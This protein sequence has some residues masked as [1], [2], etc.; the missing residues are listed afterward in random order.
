MLPLGDSARVMGQQDDNQWSAPTNLSVSGSVGAPQIVSHSD[1]TLIVLWPDSFEERFVFSSLESDVWSEPR[2]VE[3]PFGTNAFDP[4]LSED[5][6]TPLFNAELFVDLNGRLHATWIDGDGTLFYS[7]V[8]LAEFDSLTAWTVPVE[9]AAETRLA[10]LVVEGEQELHIAYLQVGDFESQSGVYY[11]RSEDGGEN[12]TDPV[13]LYLSQYFRLLTAET[14]NIQFVRNNGNDL[15]VAWD[16][17]PNGRVMMAQSF[18][19]GNVWQELTVIDEPDESDGLVAVTPSSV[20]LTVDNDDALHIIWQVEGGE[21]DCSLYHLWLSDGSVAMQ[22]AIEELEIVDG[23]SDDIRFLNGD[24]LMLY[25]LISDERYLSVWNETEWTT[26]VVQ[27]G[28]SSFVTDSTFRE[29]SFSCGQDIIL[30]DDGLLAASCGQELAQDIWVQERALAELVEAPQI[31]QIWQT[32]DLVAETETGIVSPILIA[33]EVE[34]LHAFWSIIPSG[35]DLMQDSLPTN[36]LHSSWDMASWSRAT[37]VLQSPTGAA[38]QHAATSDGN[39]RVLVVWAGGNRGAIFFSWAGS[40]NASL[41]SEWTPPLQLSADETIASDPVIAV[42]SSGTIYVIFAVSINEGRGLYLVK[43]QDRGNT[44]SNPTMIFDGAAA[45]WEMVAHPRLTITAPG[46]LHLDWLQRPGSNLNNQDSMYYS[47]SEDGGENWTTAQLVDSASQEQLPI[48]WHDIRALEG[49]LV[50][51]IWQDWSPG[52]LALWHQYSSDGVNWREPSLIGSFDGLSTISTMALDKAGDPHLLYTFR[53]TNQEDGVGT[54]L[55][56]WVWQGVSWQEEEV[57]RVDD[58]VMTRIQ[59]LA[60]ISVGEQLGVLIAGKSSSELQQSQL[61]FTL[62]EI[63]VDNDRPIPPP[64]PTETP[65]PSPTPAATLTPE[66]TPTM[67]FSLEVEPVNSQ[68]RLGP[69]DQTGSI[70]IMVV[71]F[72]ILLGSP[73]LVQYFRRSRSRS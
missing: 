70:V 16:D 26:A 10:A 14:A 6:P 15:H 22:E 31:A 24:G 20:R 5:D 59:A 56:H 61:L 18:D 40:Q 58:D 66:P 36:I 41:K 49:G 3:L 54:S 62:R 38:V 32:P 28:L 53:D 33:D 47:F 67:V 51:R 50:H 73:F 9:V 57:L 17:W 8:M 39:G 60:A 29:V 21:E 64:L 27:P 11:Q 30:T 68:V 2:G 65:A 55:R 25:V 71:I 69:F 35:I 1:G 42:D 48:L 19:G 63:E 23:C 52:R 7:H 46:R 43:S 34:R 44:W 12:W 72:G 37:A 45:E 13:P 4:D